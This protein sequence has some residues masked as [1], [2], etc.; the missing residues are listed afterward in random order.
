MSLT[1]CPSIKSS[2]PSPIKTGTIPQSLSPNVV[3]TEVEAKALIPKKT[4][5]AAGLG[6]HTDVP[7]EAEGPKDD[8]QLEQVLR[9]AKRGWTL[10][11]I[12]PHDK[13]PLKGFGWKELAT[14]NEEQ[15]RHL[16]QK[17]PNCNWAARTGAESNLFVVDVDGYKGGFD[18]LHDLQA[19]EGQQLPATLT[20]NTG[21]G[22]GKHYIFKLPSNGQVVS[23]AVGERGLGAG[24][25]VRGDGG[26]IVIPPSTTTTSYTFED[27][28]VE[29]T[30]APEWLLQLLQHPPVH[31]GRHQ[32]DIE[33]R[34]G[35]IPVGMRD[36]TLFRRACALRREGAQSRKY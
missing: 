4:G 20:T 24:L 8:A 23:N 27:E 3:A 14:R 6:C 36:D 11:P 2:Q 28:N 19:R 32:S 5:A 1:I 7:H 21:S 35:L 13:V 31:E 15:L 29:I 33:L 16:F 18:T 12:T 25:D 10:F 22:K 30:D 34:G 9:L 26:Y 17:Y